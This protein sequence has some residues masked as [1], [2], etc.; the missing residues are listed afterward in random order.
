VHDTNAAL[1]EAANRRVNEAIRRGG[2]PGE[3]G[4][5]FRCECAR[6]GCTELIRLSPAEY[7]HVRADGRRFLVVP[8][9]EDTALETVVERHSAYVVVEKRGPAGEFAEAS[10][11]RG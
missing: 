11:P 4:G 9:H 2:W 10:D 8:G 1:N 7:E 5:P 6:Q 3:D